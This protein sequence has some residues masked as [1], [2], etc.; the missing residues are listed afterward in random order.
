MSNL[1]K[2]SFSL[3]GTVLSLFFIVTL[4]LIS[5]VGIQLFYFSKQTALE[6][7]DLKLHGLTENISTTIANDEKSNFDTVKLLSHLDVK[8]K[9][10]EFYTNI[11]D[12][13][14]YVFGIYIADEKGDFFQVINLNTH[15]L[16]KPFYG[17]LEG[18]RWLKIEVN[19]DKKIRTIS[20]LDKNLNITSIK[21]EDTSYDPRK[22]PWYIK[23]IEHTSPIKTEPY[24]FYSIDSIGFTYAY[25]LENRKNVIALDLLSDYFKHISINHIEEDYM[26]LYLFNEDGVLISSLTNKEDL[27]KEF[28]KKYRDF[29]EFYEAKVVEL[30]KNKYIIQTNKIKNDYDYN[31]I[32]I[33]SDYEK[34]ID[35]SLNQSLS[36]VLIFFLASLIIFPIIILFSNRIINP[37]YELVEQINRVKDR[38]YE[39]VVDV[40]ASTLEVGILANSF[41]QM[42]NSIFKYQHSLEALVETRTK[43]L[44]QKN[45]E[46]EKLSITDKLTSLYNRVKLDNVLNEE[47]NR[48][49]R[50][51]FVFCVIMLD[52]DFFKK[53]NDTF[54][55]QIGDDVLK[56]LASIIKNCTR[57]TDI[58]G[59]WGGEEFLVICPNTNLEGAKALA[60]NMNKAVKSH[61][62]STYPEKLTISL[63]ISCYKNALLKPEELVANADIAL[64]RAK[65]NGRDRVEIY[66]KEI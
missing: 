3:R 22:R 35:E 47:F 28:S 45:E 15:R 16:L 59:R 29:S 23:A 56:E 51:N 50:Y 66:D 39:G 46:L 43:E 9:T 4:F 57:A 19:Q 58:V 42:A 1:I 65:E 5:I 44:I 61:T 20:L 30:N 33:I 55:H 11:L 48:S 27:F 63:G 26:N 64:Y 53:V 14:P 62:F 54:G 49:K 41:S 8:S 37:I 60:I 2:N 36:L 32:A 24:K 10:L 52:I 18:D 21:N 13:H 25:A 34:T 12:S 17:A 38:N 40:K 31:Y 6:S 7:I